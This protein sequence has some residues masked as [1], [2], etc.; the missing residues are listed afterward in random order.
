MKQP[1]ERRQIQVTNQTKQR[2]FAPGDLGLLGE[3]LMHQLRPGQG[4]QVRIILVADAE[5]IALNRRF[6]KLEDSTDVIS[7]NITD[8]GAAVLDG[9]VY[10]CVDAARRQAK[11]YAVSLGEELQRLTAHG[12]FHLL[13]HEDS[14]P[15]QKLV[16]TRLEN[17]A[18]QAF[19]KYTMR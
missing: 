7:F 4:W 16:M 3:L 18:L 1:R 19:K 9:E 5:I 6:F 8:A 15:Q 12:L 11:E 2:G 10:I 13:G 17:E 14:D